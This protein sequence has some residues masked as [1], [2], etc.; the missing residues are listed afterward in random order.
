[1]RHTLLTVALL[2][3][4]SAAS[5]RYHPLASPTLLQRFILEFRDG[6]SRAYVSP[7]RDALLGAVVDACR[8]I[9]NGNVGV[10]AEPTRAGDRMGPLGGLGADDQDLQAVYLE[11]MRRAAKAGA[12]GPY[13]AAL[14]RAAVEFVS[15]TGPAGLVYGFKRAPVQAV[16]PEI[17]QAR[18]AGLCAATV[19]RSATSAHSPPSQALAAASSIDEVP[20]AVTVTLLGA[21]LRLVSCSAGCRTLVG[22]ADAPAALLAAI[23]SD[24][25]GVCYAGLELLRRVCHNSRRPADQDEDLEAAAK[26]LFLT[27]DMRVAVIQALDMHGAA[28]SSAA[29]GGGRTGTEGTLVMVALTG[30]LDSILVSHADTTP[31]DAADHLVQLTASRYSSLLALFRCQCTGIVE[32]TAMLMRLIVDLAEVGTCRAMQAAALS[33][34]VWLRHFHN[35]MFA[36]SLDQRYVSRFLVELWSTGNATAREVLRHMLPAGLLLYL[37][38]PRLSTQVRARRHR[39][40][41]TSFC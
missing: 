13:N 11:N 2:D 25:E 17:V 31:Q 26:K 4:A 34:G 7:L 5:S 36:P 6:S 24:D 38:M 8:N 20:S 1:M 23:R 19:S 28:G 18:V 15:N 35:A 9:G 27:V 29:S 30:L 10:L 16:L 3:D 21:L 22:H 12:G 32:S 14:V 37:G 40:L 41:V 33:S 39:L